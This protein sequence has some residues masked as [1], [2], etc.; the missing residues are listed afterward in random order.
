LTP[1]VRVSGLI[2]AFDMTMRGL[3]SVSGL[4]YDVYSTFAI[5]AILAGAYGI[6]VGTAQTARSGQSR[7]DPARIELSR[8]AGCRRTKGHARRFV[9]A[10][11]GTRRGIV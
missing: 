4:Y 9:L 10:V 11:L 1:S 8:G 3:R 5:V 2:S 6:A 7:S